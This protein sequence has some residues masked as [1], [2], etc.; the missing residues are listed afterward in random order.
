VMLNV[1]ILEDTRIL[2]CWNDPVSDETTC[3]L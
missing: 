1:T 2:I 3:A